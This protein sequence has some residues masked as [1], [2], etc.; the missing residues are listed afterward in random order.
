T[1]EGTVRLDILA[2]SS[3]IGDTA[4]NALA[5]DFTTGEVYTRAL[6]GN[7]VWIRSETGGLWSGNAN[8]EN[9]VVADNVGNTADFTTLEIDEDN[10]VHLDSPRT[11]GNVLFGDSDINTSASWIVDNNG[12]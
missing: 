3:G 8:W 6:V 1:G 2:T 7:G 4:G 9:G 10:R 5:G 11:I 12:D